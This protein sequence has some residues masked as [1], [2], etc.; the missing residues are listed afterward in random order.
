M[1]SL[2]IPTPADHRASLCG[3]V[4]DHYRIDNLAAR[5]GMADIFRATDIRTSRIVAIKVPHGELANDPVVM[6]S[7]ASEERILQKFDHPGIVRACGHRVTV[8]PTW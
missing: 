5:G 7:L 2:T 1:E 3:Q 6:R 4:L 8:V